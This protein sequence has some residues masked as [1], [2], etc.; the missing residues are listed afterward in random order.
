MAL[1][2]ALLVAGMLLLAL[3]TILPG[4]I[5]GIMGVCC[6]GA[7]IVL[8]YLRFGFQTGNT[9][10]AIATVGIVV[11]TVIYIKYFPDSP[12]AQLFVSKRAIGQIG[13]EDPSL[14]NQTGETFTPLRPSGMAMING[15]RTDVISEGGFVE[16]GKAVRVVAVEGLRIVVRPV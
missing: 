16:A 3:E 1:V 13:N 12:M 9:V 11:G 7:A 4:L 5:A 14:V 8:G 15:K 6:I 2:V 10:L